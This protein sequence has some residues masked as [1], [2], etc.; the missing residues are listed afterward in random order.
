MPSTGLFPRVLF[1]VQHLLGIGHWRRAAILARAMTQAGLET[2]VLSGGS[3][4]DALVGVYSEADTSVTRSL[5]VRSRPIVTPDFPTTS[6]VENVG[7]RPD[8]EFD[9]MTID[10][11]LNQGDTFVKAFTGQAVKLVKK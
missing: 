1:Y 6:Y 8:F 10:N 5:V 4:E 3:P 7:V 11:L 2:T 9:Y